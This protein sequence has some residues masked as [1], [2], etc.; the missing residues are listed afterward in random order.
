MGAFE[1]DRFSVFRL[2]QIFEKLITLIKIIQS[3]CYLA[4]IHAIST[5]M[6]AKIFS[7]IGVPQVGKPKPHQNMVG[8]AKLLS[9]IICY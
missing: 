9:I 5:Q 8:G 6:C 1:C 3:G 4:Y 2:M 7:R